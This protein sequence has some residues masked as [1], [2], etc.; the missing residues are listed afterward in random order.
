LRE[1]TGRT[2]HLGFTRCVVDWYKKNQPEKADSFVGDADP[3]VI[4][5]QKIFKSVSLA[6]GWPPCP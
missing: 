5:V 4:S 3:G 6:P 1:E 2:D